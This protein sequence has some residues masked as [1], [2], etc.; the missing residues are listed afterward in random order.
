[1]NL[2]VGY[3]LMESQ[4]GRLLKNYSNARQSW[5]AWCFMVNFNCKEKNFE[6]V[7]Y[8]DQHEL[9][10]HLRYLALK[11]FHIEAYKILKKSPNNKDNIF[12]LLEKAAALDP[13]KKT[14]VDYC[15]RELEMRNDTIK[16]ICDLRDKFYA[17]LDENYED[18]LLNTKL[19]KIHDCFIAVE[20]AIMAITSKGVLQ[21]FLD[22]IPSRD[23]LSL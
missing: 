3:K 9:L 21:S 19:S 7:R 23:E 5:E 12:A 16:G 6:I 15:L 17:H 8:I 18:Y 1:M 2:R 4:I 22:K 11:D 13:G 10:F 20:R 14:E